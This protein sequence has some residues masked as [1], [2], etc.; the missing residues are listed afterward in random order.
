MP[1]IDEYLKDLRM[2]DV[3]AVPAHRKRNYNMPPE[4]IDGAPRK[5]KS[6]R[7]VGHLVRYLAK[8]NEYYIL[9][10]RPRFG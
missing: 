2:E 7:S 10:G 5:P 9:F 8:L 6:F 3:L 1:V 4:V